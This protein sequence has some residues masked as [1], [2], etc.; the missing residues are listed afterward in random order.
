MRQDNH[1]RG[2]MKGGLFMNQRTRTPEMLEVRMLD[3]DALSIYIGMGKT[4]AVE[5]GEKCGAKRKF[6]KRALYDKK[7]I[8]KAIDEL[9]S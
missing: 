9:E 8:D 3:A 5:F 2:F 6:G 1:V 4:R 7:V